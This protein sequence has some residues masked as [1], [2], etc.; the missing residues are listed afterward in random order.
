MK[1][2]LLSLFITITS[3]TFSQSSYSD[4]NIS[5]NTYNQSN[6][7]MV[8]NTNTPK[9]GLNINTNTRV[10]L[11]GYGYNDSSIPLGVGMMLGGATF[12]TAGL[13]TVPDY[14]VGPNGETQTKPFWRQG[15]RM[16]AVMTGAGLFTAGIVIS[17][18]R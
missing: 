7:Y 15:A 10:S 5:M 12:I 11:G 9:L 16:L 14:D 2:F 8:M 1:T 6:P 17:I 18:S 4:F 3:I 13:L